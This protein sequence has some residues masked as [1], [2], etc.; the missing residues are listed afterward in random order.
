[1]KTKLSSCENRIKFTDIT[2]SK[3]KNFQ[4][5]RVGERKEKI[6][7]ASKISI[8]EIK[9]NSKATISENKVVEVVIDDID[10]EDVVQFEAFNNF[11]KDPMNNNVEEESQCVLRYFIYLFIHFLFKVDL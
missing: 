1:M 6:V 7:K 5:N 3:R 9:M 8:P 4:S 2:T 10:Y 11:C